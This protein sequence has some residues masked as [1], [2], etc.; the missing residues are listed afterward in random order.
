MYL[1]TRMYTI[2]L[3]KVTRHQNFVPCRTTTRMDARLPLEIIGVAVSESIGKGDT[4][5]S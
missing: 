3:I 2:L 4:E 1:H 5:K